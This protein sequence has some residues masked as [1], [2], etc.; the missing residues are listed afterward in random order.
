MISSLVVLQS[1][2]QETKQA[3]LIRIIG[4][5]I[6]AII[7]GLLCELFGYGYWQLFLVIF[8]SIYVVNVFLGEKAARLSSATSGVI[9]IIGLMNPEQAPWFN[10]LMRFLESALSVGIVLLMVT[11]SAK[12]KLR[13]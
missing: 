7:A 8:L 11:L 1:L 12:I 9:V 4:S 2:L 3:S 13:K 5:F 10:S 6:G